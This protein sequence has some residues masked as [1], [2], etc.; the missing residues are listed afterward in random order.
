[1]GCQEMGVDV[2]PRLRYSSPINL[3]AAVT[4]L[5]ARVGCVLGSALMFAACADTQSGTTTS[6]TP[7]ERKCASRDVP[8]AEAMA[9]EATLADPI[10]SDVVEG[11]VVQIPV[12]FHVITDNAGNGDVP[13][14]QIDAQLDVMN[15]FRNFLLPLR[16]LGPEAC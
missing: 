4:T 13:D 9:L 10:I 6:A 5:T 7:T 3:E 2:G 12:F 16:E 14:A 1:M 11:T 15:K 8:A